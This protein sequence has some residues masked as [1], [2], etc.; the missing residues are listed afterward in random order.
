MKGIHKFAPRSGAKL[1]RN[2]EYPGSIPQREALDGSGELSNGQ[3]VSSESTAL[4]TR[5]KEC[6]GRHHNDPDVGLF[7]DAWEA[8][9]QL[10]SDEGSPTPW[11]CWLWYALAEHL[12]RAGHDVEWMLIHVDPRCPHCSSTTKREPS[13]TGYPNIRCASQCRQPDDVT[14]DVVERVLE[15]YNATFNEPIERIGIF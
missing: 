12:D 11:D 3:L 15:I 4:L 14:V 2:R 7:L 10:R 8:I 5:L 1:S 13:V 6:H 9:Q